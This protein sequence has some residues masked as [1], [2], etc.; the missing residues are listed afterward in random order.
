[1]WAM[2]MYECVRVQLLQSCPTLYNPMDCSPPGSS[3]HGILQARILE[4]VDMPSSRGSSWP[5]DQT[6]VSC[7]A[8]KFFT[9]EL[10]GK[11][12]YMCM[13]VCLYIYVYVYIMEYFSYCCCLVLKS[14][15]T[16]CNTMGCSLPGISQERILVWVATSFSR[17]SSWPR[18]QTH[19]SCLGRQILYLW[20]TREVHSGIPLSH[21]KELEC[22]LPSSLP[23]GLTS[24]N[25]SR[26]HL[27]FHIL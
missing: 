16:L 5:R 10:P 11:P 14:C 17:G 26:L 9:T 19:I 24:T 12:M 7:I 15:L 27:S 3:V 20:T 21:K 23:E 25:F 4:W 18:D 22:G 6:R 8:G 2:H 13:C 1:M